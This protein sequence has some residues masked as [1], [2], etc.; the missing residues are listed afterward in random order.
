[1]EVRNKP[2]FLSAILYV[3]TKLNKNPRIQTGFLGVSKSSTTLHPMYSQSVCLT[4]GIG[5]SAVTLT[6]SH[7]VTSCLSQFY[8]DWKWMKI[9]AV[10]FP[11]HFQLF[12]H[13]A[14]DST[15][16]HTH[17][18]THIC[19]CV[20]RGVEA[21]HHLYFV[22]PMSHL[23][24]CSFVNCSYGEFMY[25]YICTNNGQTYEMLP[26]LLQNCALFVIFLPWD[27][28]QNDVKLCQQENVLLKT[29]YVLSE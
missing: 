11:V 21:I 13:D 14:D 7:D 22:F 26:V 20:L 28:K 23:Q 15:H 27:F 24:R 2:H 29:K 1:M 6:F 3:V 19:V 12:S 8:C 4:N 17:T 10:L 5:C 16:T 25:M 9:L 18:H